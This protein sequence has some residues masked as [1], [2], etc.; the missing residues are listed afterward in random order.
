MG[1]Q[2][3]QSMKD[4]QRHAMALP[5]VNVAYGVDGETQIIP[6]PSPTPAPTPNSDLAKFQ[7]EQNAAYETLFANQNAGK[8]SNSYTRETSKSL[9]AIE[10]GL[11]KNVSPTKV[12]HT[13]SSAEQ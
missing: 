13:P 5:P 8:P 3:T 1:G 11:N 12:R 10:H 7:G 6:T 9:A 4:L 2:P